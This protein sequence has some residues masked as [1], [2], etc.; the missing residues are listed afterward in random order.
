LAKILEAFIAKALQPWVKTF[1]SDYYEQLFRLRG[2]KYPQFT[3]KRRQYFGVLTNDIVYQR[4]APGVLEELKKMIPRNDEGRPTA[5]YFQRLTTNVGYPKLREHLGS[6]VAIMNLSAD[7]KDFTDK[8]NYI[9][10]RYGQQMLIPYDFDL[11]DPNTDS[12]QGL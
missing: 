5:K 12:G 1:P 3:V 6:V 10:P 4:L 2:L 11:Y 8:L 7:Y 9:H